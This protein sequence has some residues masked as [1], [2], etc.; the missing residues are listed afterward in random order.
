MWL[1]ALDRQKLVEL[2][3]QKGKELN[4][5][6]ENYLRWLDAFFEKEYCDD[7]GA[8]DITSKAVLAENKSRKAFLK[9]KQAGVIA[10]IE[11]VSWFL[12]KHGL[13]VK[14]YIKDGKQVLGG[15]TVLEIQGTQKDIL[16]TERITLN[17]L[18]RM[19]GIATETK[20]LVELLKDSG[21][22]IAATRKA[23]LRYLDKKAVFLSGGLT[24]R[25]GLWDAILIKDNHLET[26]KSEGTKDYIETAITKASAFADKVEFIEIEVTSHEEAIRAAK[27]FKSRHLK[28]PCVVMLD[29]MAP[30]AIEGTIKTLRE[31]NLYDSVLLEAS[32]KITPENIQEYAKTGIDVVSLGYL[33]HSA[34]VLDM[35]LEMTL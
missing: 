33:T 18:Q 34:K 24:H 27:K 30:K 12:R 28:V 29:N 22:R 6:N 4:L 17:V 20:R 10:G 2:A 8:G 25:F 35:S 31:N 5:A 9:A 21:T 16:A 15:E 7:V 3:Y 14:V 13:E 1:D 23:P 26:L 19:S 32:G 11:E